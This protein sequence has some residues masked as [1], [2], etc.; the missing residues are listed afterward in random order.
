MFMAVVEA[1]EEVQGG[2]GTTDAEYGEN[3]EDIDGPGEGGDGGDG[4]GGSGGQELGIASLEPSGQMVTGGSDPGS[5]K[6]IIEY[7]G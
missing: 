1:Q 4:D 5:G 3:A 7:Y 2:E 6:I